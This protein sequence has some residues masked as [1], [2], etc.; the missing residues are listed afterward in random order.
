MAKVK[1]LNWF[2][3][4][5]LTLAV[6]GILTFIMLHIGVVVVNETPNP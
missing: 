2:L 5:I 6:I 1:W 4:I 3:M